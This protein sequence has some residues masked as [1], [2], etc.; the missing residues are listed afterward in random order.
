MVVGNLPPSLSAQMRFRDMAWPTAND[1]LEAMQHPLRRF[2]KPDLKRSQA[3]TGPNGKP[4]PLS[5]TTCDVYELRSAGAI[6]RWAIGCFT[7]EPKGLPRRYQLINNHLQKH[8]LPCVV[9]T[10]YNE[11]GIQIRGRWYPITRSRW[12]DGLP[13]NEFVR[14]I[15]DH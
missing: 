8:P 10:E 12:V 1:Y 9:E 15:I 6:D 11:Q 3:G 7:Q 2:C 4:L 13:L 5:G 14:E